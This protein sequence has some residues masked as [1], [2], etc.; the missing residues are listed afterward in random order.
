MEA[1]SSLLMS[2]PP[3]SSPAF[4]C[5][6]QLRQQF[7]S[8]PLLVSARAAT[9]V[10]TLSTLRL[11]AVIGYVP[12]PQRALL[13][14]D[15]L[16]RLGPAWVKLGQMLATRPDIMPAPHGA[17]L[18]ELHDSVP[19]FDGEVAMRVVHSELPNATPRAHLVAHAV[20]ADLRRDRVHLHTRGERVS[21]RCTVKSREKTL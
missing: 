6:E 5:H 2:A 12:A 3:R 16:I 8:K 13:L 17:A 20:A 7:A 9:I 15:A 18:R 21:D 10:S 19:P 4:Y 11:R 1:S 14:K